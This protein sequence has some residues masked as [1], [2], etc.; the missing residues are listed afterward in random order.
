MTTRTKEEY[1]IVHA[2]YPEHTPLMALQGQASNL[3]QAKRM[4][5]EWD[6]DY[7]LKQYGP[8]RILHIVTTTTEIERT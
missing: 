8:H 4:A 1:R 3:P 6:A 7:D 5:D 2:R